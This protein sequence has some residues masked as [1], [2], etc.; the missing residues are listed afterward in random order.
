MVRQRKPD[1]SAVRYGLDKCV[2][3]GLIKFL[4]VGY[5]ST[6]KAQLYFDITL[7]SDVWFR[8]G[9]REAFAFLKGVEVVEKAKEGR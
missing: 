3:K 2:E 4:T 5:T 8:F 6:A 1:I 9:L 7:Q